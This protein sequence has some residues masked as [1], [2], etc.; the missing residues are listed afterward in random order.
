MEKGGRLR[1]KG[2]EGGKV[3]GKKRR[4]GGRLRVKGGEGGRQR[5]KGGE[6]E[7]KVKG[8]R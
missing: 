1:V 5:V 7:E 4:R 8:K 3:K 6:G 2:G